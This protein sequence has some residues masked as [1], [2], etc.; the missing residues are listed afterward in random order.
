MKIVKL[1]A[2]AGTS[3]L[4]LAIGL[5][6]KQMER[7]Q[8]ATW[9]PATVS[10]AI[11][12]TSDVTLTL[13]TPPVAAV[14]SQGDR[15]TVVLSG[16]WTNSGAGPVYVQ[17]SDSAATFVVPSPSL[18]KKQLRYL[19]PVS[20][21]KSKPA[22][23]Y[24]GTLTVRACADSLCTQVYPGTEHSIAYSVAVK[25]VGEWETV[26]RNARHDGYV[27][28]QVDPTRYQLAWAWQR[29]TVGPVTSLVTDGDNVYFTEPGPTSVTVRALRAADGIEHWQH[30]FS[31]GSG[32]GFSAPAV[33]E[34]TVYVANAGFDASWLYALRASDGE[35]QYQSAFA[36][37]WASL[38]NPTVC[39]G[40]VYVNAGYYTGV[41]YAYDSTDGSATWNASAGTIEMNTPAVDD[42]YVYAYN[43]NSLDVLDVGDGTPHISIGPSPGGWGNR[44]NATVTLGSPDHVLVLDGSYGT[45]PDRQLLDYSV[46]DGAIRWASTS[47]YS[48]E[49][50]VAKGVVYATSNDTHTLDALDEATGHVLWSWKPMTPYGYTFMGNVIVTDNAVFVSTGLR[51]YAVSLRN[52]R[53]L[54]SAP[55]P[56]TMAM[57]GNRTLFVTTLGDYQTSGTI[58]AYRLQ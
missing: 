14:V 7:R 2:I 5:Q 19:I 25:P 57:S 37:Q 17:A 54:W 12:E 38:M 24:S 48:S 39:N 11:P 31:V 53:T 36:S 28:V 21:P 44:N 8:T 45:V 33:S 46:A 40:K 16:A 6:G 51:I 49:P 58:T 34:G 13:A 55:S 9:R 27:P 23:D 30:A 50:A 20:V 4:L 22:G 56:G 10:A 26:Q 32:W 35:Q 41:V 18:M 29:P 1:G 47:R 42:S 3:L 52:R 15:Y 43:G